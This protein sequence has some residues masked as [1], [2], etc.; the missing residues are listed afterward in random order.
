MYN[1]PCTSIITN[2]YNEPSGR[3][4]HR[5]TEEPQA[6]R[7]QPATMNRYETI[8]GNA[9][10]ASI[11]MTSQETTVNALEP[12]II[13]NHNTSE[14]IRKRQY[15]TRTREQRSSSVYN[16]SGI[17]D[18]QCKFKDLTITGKH[19]YVK[20]KVKAQQWYAWG[21]IDDT[22]IDAFYY[23]DKEAIKKAVAY[24][25][26]GQGDGSYRF[27]PKSKT[28]RARLLAHDADTG[29]TETGALL[30]SDIPLMTWVGGYNLLDRNHY[31]TSSDGYL[32]IDSV[33]FC[34]IDAVEQKDEDKEFGFIEL[35]KLIFSPWATFASKKC[36]SPFI[37]VDI[38]N[39]N[40]MEAYHQAVEQCL[41]PKCSFYI[42]NLNPDSPHQHHAQFFWLVPP[43]PKKSRSKKALKKT[44]LYKTIRNAFNHI[45]GGDINANGNRCRNPFYY[46]TDFATT[47][48]EGG[49]S[50]S[51]TVWTLTGL[52]EYIKDKPWYQNTKETKRNLVFSNGN[53]STLDDGTM[54]ALD[55]RM[56]KGMTIPEGRR[57][58]VTFRVGTWV[59][60]HTHDI[61][62]VEKEIDALRY[63][64]DTG[65][66]KREKQGIIRS[67]RNYHDKHYDPGF[68]AQTKKKDRKNPIAMVLGAKG[69]NA[70][71]EAQVKAREQNLEQGCQVRRDRIRDTKDRIR[72]ILDTCTPV[73]VT[74]GARNHMETP[75]QMVLRCLGEQYRELA[76]DYQR[77]Y[78]QG[79]LTIREYRSL[80]KSCKVP[81][82]K[83]VRKYLKEVVADEAT[84]TARTMGADDWDGVKVPT[85]SE[86][87]PGASS[88]IRMMRAADTVLVDW[89]S[90]HD[91][92]CAV[93]VPLVA[94]VNRIASIVHDC[95]GTAPGDKSL[96][97]LAAVMKRKLFD[98]ALVYMH[99]YV[100]D[101]VDWSM[102]LNPIGRDGGT[103]NG[104]GGSSGD[105]WAGPRG[106]RYSVDVED[107]LNA[108]ALM[109]ML[110]NGLEGLN[111]WLDAR[112][113]VTVDS[114]NG[115]TA[116]VLVSSSGNSS[117]M[118]A[119][120]RLTQLV[121]D[122]VA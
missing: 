115:D 37:M 70:N 67:I 39:A 15:L 78:R 11:E 34:P 112:D 49:E 38:D 59:M 43:V 6:K 106:V 25:I 103:V 33:M 45:L 90:R 110:A 81:N 92:Y 91:E 107:P 47:F 14:F 121:M 13:I 105:W 109:G 60:W 65:F 97:A 120:R 102:E 30:P 19:Q 5:L 8:T 23:M 7:K 63:A 12:P 50:E 17:N 84:R 35:D 10:T 113:V 61:K 24:R 85:Q 27:T 21:T 58:E 72:S 64:D 119:A 88:V 86:S 71:T 116:T 2:R 46:E 55:P 79:L 68:L 104:A 56:L 95:I 44:D 18:I 93:S 26:Q 99:G 52:Y 76:E 40:A 74:S 77:Q 117:S 96:E 80:M 82:I 51:I 31:D 28:A 94:T 32:P 101:A 20:N 53:Q 9:T 16:L 100:P 36:T 48:I 73:M 1:A 87:Q 69:G 122:G 29:D 111:R 3:T 4:L 62:Q 89:L 41:I 108:N 22:I 98:T 118:N 66:T 57:N 42:E 83:T 114:M 75:A 54:G